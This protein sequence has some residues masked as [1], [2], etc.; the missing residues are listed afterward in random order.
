MSKRK[1]RVAI[2]L[3][4]VV[5]IACL[6]VF[7]P[8]QHPEQLPTVLVHSPDNLEQLAARIHENQSRLR[9]VF[10]SQPSEKLAGVGI[11]SLTGGRFGIQRMH[12]QTDIMFFDSVAE[13]V[14]DNAQEKQGLAVSL[15]PRVDIGCGCCFVD[16]RSDQS[17]ISDQDLALMSLV[18]DVRWL[19]VSY[20]NISGAGLACFAEKKELEW[21]SVSGCNVDDD[22]LRGIAA[23]TSLRHLDLS[24]NSISGPGLQYLASLKNLETL[25]LS[26]NRLDADAL[27]H[28]PALPN[29]RLLN[30]DDTQ[31][32][33]TGITN[34]E[35]LTH[36]EELSLRKTHVSDQNFSK[37]GRLDSLQILDLR[38]THVADRAMEAV[39]RQSNLRTLILQYAP[40]SG[41]GLQHLVV[42]QHLEL[43]DLIGCYMGDQDLKSI[44]PLLRTANLLVGRTNVTPSGLIQ[45]ASKSL[46]YADL[47]AKSAG[48][49]A[50]SA[51]D[52]NRI[53]ERLPNLA[54][55]HLLIKPTAEPIDLRFARLKHLRE[56]TVSLPH[57]IRSITLEDLPALTE[58]RVLT[59]SQDRHAPSRIATKVRLQ[60][61]P[62][63]SDLKFGVSTEIEMDALPQ[64]RHVDLTL[65]GLANQ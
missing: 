27:K 19:R 1:K 62:K 10:L 56:M 64:L 57:D 32:D 16:V 63:L 61:L 4:T 31:I 11:R 14:G 58:F 60:Q 54:A 17:V 48:P 12:Q 43:L 51:E 40:V 13:A 45:H 52:A 33:G 22:D 55:L 3:L 8:R 15:T 34:L 23:V 5:S 49:A 24:E 30:V 20:P 36:L 26:K 7:V 9:T 47:M 2:A 35:K 39:A 37:L 18:D 46:Q 29:L 28:F 38:H 53:S 25:Y 42:L 50:V 21:L 59:Y 65:Q 44:K 6:L 41:R